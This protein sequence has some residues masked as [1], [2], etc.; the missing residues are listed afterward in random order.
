MER[1]KNAA[2][3]CKKRVKHPVLTRFY[4]ISHLSTLNSHLSPV[5]CVGVFPV[6]CLKQRLKYFGSVKPQA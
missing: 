6:L 1:G 3:G 5:N 4:T 2:N